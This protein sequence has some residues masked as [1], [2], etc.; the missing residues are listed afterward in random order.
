M[1]ARDYQIA[2]LDR[3]REHMRAGKR[4]ILLQLPTGGGKCLGRGTLVLMFDGTVKPVEEVIVGDKLIGPDSE[5][6][7]VLTTC[8]GTEPL[9]R[10]IPTK[11]DAYVV[12]ESHILSLRLTGLGNLATGRFG[13]R[14]TGQIVNISL[15][16]YLAETPY[17][18]HIA[19][20]WRSGVD[21]K[22]GERLPIDP[23]FLGVWLGDGTS[24]MP[25]VTA[26]EPEIIEAVQAEASK[27]G[28]HVRIDE[29]G[30]RSPIHCITG[31]HR[32]GIENTLTRDLRSLKVLGD[33]HIPLI[34]K[35]AS[36]TDRLALLAGL[37]D[38]D[39]HLN[40]PDCID[41]V[42]KSRRLADDAIFLARGLGFAAYR[43]ACRK[44]CTNNGISG[45]YHRFTV[46]GGI[47]EI[48]SRLARKQSDP[49][50][51]KKSVL[52]VG[53]VAQPIGEGE[54]F[55]F[56]IDGDH[57][58][59]LGDFTVT[60][61]TVMAAMML[62]GSAQRGQASQFIVHR[63]ELI[64]QT[65]ATFAAVGIPH[66]F[67]A[68][69]MPVNGSQPVQLAGIQTLV[70]RLDL[71]RVPQLCVWDECHHLTA[72]MWDRVFQ[73]YPNAFHIGLTA[74][75]QRLDGRGLADHFDVMV[76]GPSVR[77]L[78]DRGYLSPFEYYAPGKPDLV[79]VHTVAGDF[80]RG[81][82]AGA[83]DKP[84]LV[85]DIVEHYQRLAAGQQ[86]I[87]FAAG[88]EH[89]RHI[90]EAFASEGIRAAHV[91]GSMNDNDR[92]RAVEGF[93]RGDIQL[94][95]NV[96]LFGEGFDVPGLVYAGLA[97]PTKSLALHL[98][99]VGRSLRVME[100]KA[101]AIICDHAGNAFLHGM[102]DD[103]RHWTLE[104]RAK[105]TR[106]SGPSDALG[107]HSCPECYRVTHSTVPVCPQCGYEFPI[108]A[109]NPAWEEGE[110]FRLDGVASKEAAAQARKDEE[111]ACKTAA[112]L[113][114]LGIERGYKNPSGW[115]RQKI[116]LRQRWKGGSRFAKRGNV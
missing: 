28:L 86:G 53:I 95:S 44:T 105:S 43:K 19:K 70:N 31:G 6:R 82:V 39:G 50:Q 83:M 96:D 49:R 60:H 3:A 100:G 64:Q 99:Q 11:G 59:L 48:P 27:R 79:G 113:M 23:Y 32:G 29:S 78:I 42:F 45:D 63:K 69:G 114:R 36:R 30:E 33:K 40:K 116:E 1:K 65:S 68:S 108:K 2:M 56:E 107:V 103:P 84:K 75:P 66:G 24:A 15:K 91:D 12:N 67:I 87:V 106:A 16:A 101:N 17:F 51:Q 80:N 5:P 4:R 35:T 111:R 93:R 72:G 46:S 54:Y 34:Y 74:T 10:I 62:G 77:Q 104:G 94:L 8:C 109:R 102:P 71:A 81:E 110:L 97:R 89:S 115:A 57:M 112:E 7:K 88:R 14:K 18:R 85:G 61:N 76:L 92:H 22:G 73:Q 41:F 25:H 21:W 37:L 9:Y 26:I 13:G 20:G 55:G 58:F 38:T 90:A 52:N 47:N 98:Q